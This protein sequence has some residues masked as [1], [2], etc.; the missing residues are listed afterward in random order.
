LTEVT[1]EER[2]L[3]PEVESTAPSLG[4]VKQVINKLKIIKPQ[5]QVV[6]MLNY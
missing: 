2:N 5:S 3:M 6:L 1:E 4:K